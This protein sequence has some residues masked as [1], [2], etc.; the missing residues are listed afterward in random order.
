MTELIT[1]TALRS[2][3]SQLEP[4]EP[5]YV[6]ADSPVKE[7]IGQM[8]AN[9]IGCVLVCDDQA[10]V[11]IFTERDV[12]MRVLSKGLDVETTDVGEVMTG[13]PDCLSPEDTIAF[14]LNRMSV[15]S[16]R[17]IPLTDGT[18]RAV[19]IISVKDVFR[20]LVKATKST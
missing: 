6:R 4:R 13:N 8:Q 17:H 10:L 15:G 5:V 7:A 11:G 19:G 12:V 1:S 18:G 14:A 9:R 16:F 20:H 3:I 2:P